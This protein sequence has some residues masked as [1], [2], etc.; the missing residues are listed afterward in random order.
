MT[1]S[2]RGYRLARYRV[3][4]LVVAAAFLL[5]S[6]ALS[7]TALAQTPQGA[8]RAAATKLEAGE[9]LLRDG[10]L[11]EALAVFRTVRL[12]TPDARVQRGIAESYRRLGAHAKAYQAQQ[13]LLDRYG[14][15]MDDASRQAVQRMQ[16]ELIGLTGALAVNVKEPGARVVVDGEPIGTTPLPSPMRLDP[17]I[18][19]VEVIKSG[20]VPI[21]RGIAIEKGTTTEFADQLL[22]AVAHGQ[23][24]VSACGEGPA[25]LVL[26]GRKVGPLPWTG[27]VTEGEHE[28]AAEGVSA[29]VAPTKVTV[30]RD[31]LNLATLT[32]APFPGT[33]HVRTLN[34]GAAILL[35]GV[36]VGTSEWRGPVAA[37]VHEL[38]LAKS[39]FLTHVQLVRIAPK[40]TVDVDQIRLLPAEQQDIVPEDQYPVEGLYVRVALLGLVGATDS[41][42]FARS[43]P[44]GAVN[45]WC[46]TTAP[47]GGGA[48]VRIGRSFLS[49]LLAPELFVMAPMD[50]SLA[51]VQFPEQVFASDSAYH[52]MARRE[53]YA[54]FRYGGGA[55]LAARVTSKT[56][57]VRVTGSF[58]LGALY[59]AMV[60][61]YAATT[62]GAMI[63]DVQEHLSET[64][65][66]LAPAL[67]GDMGVTFG[68]TAGA[69]LYAGVWMMLEMSGTER[70]Q[71]VSSALGYS[72]NAL[73]RTADRGALGI[74][75]LAMTKGPQFFVGPIVG[76]RFGS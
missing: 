31:Q 28:I 66:Y 52:G 62:V 15:S 47:L 21:K 20:F 60:Y 49:G 16:E 33:L 32:L 42:E 69:K 58:G 11:R 8:A 71:A 7:S 6:C 38:S 63:P 35:D 18:R 9:R 48:E 5:A 25:E 51:T 54:F 43:C 53:E 19:T 59:R 57:T 22:A 27:S 55:G 45:A 41:N 10:H 68:H 13:E 29:R 26:D 46:S 14:A 50:V 12:E 72:V 44:P 65:T 4:A 74:P 1:A 75:P 30:K 39:G 3:M 73:T 76:L 56:E 23:L 67:V 36:P 17:G 70:A 37:G 61:A 34:A 64:R 2:A 40:Q 24:V